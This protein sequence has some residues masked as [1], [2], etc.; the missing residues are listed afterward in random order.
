MKKLQSYFLY[1][2]AAAAVILL[3]SCNRD[4]IVNPPVISNTSVGAYILSEG[5]FNPNTSKLSF[6]NRTKDSIY[7]NLFNPGSLGLLTDG[8]IYSANELFITEQGNF[9]SQGRIYKTDT[10]GTVKASLNAGINPFSLTLANNKIYVT[11]GPSNSVTVIDRTLTSVITTIPVGVY[12][13]EI[14]SIGNRVYVCN[15]SEFG[16]ATDSSV[17]VIDA[18]IDQVI[19]TINV[20][21]TPSSLAVTTDNKL[22]IGCPG[23]V[24]E[25]AIFK[26]D[27]ETNNKIDSFTNL[28]QGFCKD[29]VVMTS[30]RIAF[31]N[32]EAYSE[33]GI[34][35]YAMGTRVTSQI[36]PRPSAGLNYGLAFDDAPSYLYVCYAPSFTTSGKVIIYNSTG[37]L[38]KEFTI[39]N[40]I[41][42]RR[43]AIKK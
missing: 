2:I 24:S 1:T 10:N 4:E 37:S 14:I 42:P 36:I 9:G 19:S 28:T 41:A 33:A 20:R 3:T 25:A 26:V 39:T 29:I 40:G 22:L 32:G 34:S 17:S 8:I 31:I 27:P 43:I 13:Q 16:G 5:G 35:T 21:R 15:T 6:F 30:D 18:G 7:N 12:P 38:I 11:N 23:D